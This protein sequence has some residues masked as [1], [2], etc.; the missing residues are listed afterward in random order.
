MMYFNKLIVSGKIKISTLSVQENNCEYINCNRST[1][2][3]ETR[4]KKGS[5]HF[6]I[7]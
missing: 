1:N 4:I 2:L 7:F 5:N 6:P 3:G